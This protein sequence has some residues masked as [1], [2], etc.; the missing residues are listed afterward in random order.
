MPSLCDNQTTFPEK[1]FNVSREIQ[2]FDL[3]QLKERLRFDVSFGQREGRE[4]LQK[5]KREWSWFPC[6]K[7]SPILFHKTD[8]ATNAI[9]NSRQGCM[10]ALSVLKDQVFHLCSPPCVALG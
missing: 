3:R 8:L 7:S 6:L 9:Q 10:P 2:G 4:R 1:Q 5:E